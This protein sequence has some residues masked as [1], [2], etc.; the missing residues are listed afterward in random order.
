[1]PDR[2]IG[3]DYEPMAILDD[4]VPCMVSSRKRSRSATT[5]AESSH[6]S[7]FM[8]AHCGSL[9]ASCGAANSGQEHE[10]EVEVHG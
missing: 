7:R 1:M 9:Q 2:V 4:I 6:P 10:T 3:H 8:R 5:R